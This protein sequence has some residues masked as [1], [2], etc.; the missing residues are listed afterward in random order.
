MVH[1]PAPTVL[2]LDHD[3][4]RRA[5]LNRMLDI[6]GFVLEDAG[7]AQAALH[8]ARSQP[9]D[10]ILLD[11]NLPD[12]DAFELCRR[13]KSDPSTCGIAVIELS[14]Q[15]ENEETL[16][17]GYQS[18][19]DSCIATP[20]NPDVLA[21]IIESLVNGKRRQERLQLGRKL[22]ATGR[23]TQE[24]ARRFDNAIMGLL[25]DLGLAIE[26]ITD[27]GDRSLF[28][29]A[30]ESANR[31][32]ELSKV[33]FIGGGGT[34]FRVEHVNL[35]DLVRNAESPIRMSLPPRVQLTLEL[36][37]GLPLTHGDAGQIQ[38]LLF[39]LVRNAAESIGIEPAGAIAIRTTV[40]YLDE[41]SIRD[42]IGYEVIEPGEYV[43]LQIEDSGPGMGEHVR[44][45][46]FDPFFSTKDAGRGLGLPTVLGILRTH[47]GGIHVASAPG[48]GARV[49][50]CLVAAE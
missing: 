40:G 9:P 11:L 1:P 32:A 39:H 15:F 29:A 42:Y 8:I 19:A 22:E 17:G 25:G 13:L 26:S 38:H 21:A 35:S 16:I 20:V 46:M 48:K 41:N 31:V 12:G 18:G 14:P 37:D 34:R 2:N 5:Q 44:A 23:L 7:T 45:R 27:H 4:S 3:P 50:V 6:R 10:V 28:K 43:F 36:R 24:A 33:L 49:T 30:V 47:R